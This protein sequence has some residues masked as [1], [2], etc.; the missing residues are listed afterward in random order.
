LDVAT[1]HPVVAVIFKTSYLF[2]KV[3]TVVRVVGPI[4]KDERNKRAP[5]EK[6]APASI[7]GADFFAL[8]R[9]KPG[10][11]AWTGGPALDPVRAGDY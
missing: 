3:T 7:A 1:S 4:W 9:F 10:S 5:I 11:A 8:R 6:A 2:W